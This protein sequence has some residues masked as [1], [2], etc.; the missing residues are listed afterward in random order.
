[1]QS[2]TNKHAAT[3]MTRPTAV[4]QGD[5]ALVEASERWVQGFGAAA[6]AP[7]DACDLVLSAHRIT[8]TVARAARHLNW[9]TPDSF[10]AV[11]RQAELSDDC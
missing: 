2:K 7:E 10:V 1:M 6:L 5:A 9:E 8:Q 3:N 4:D 11:M